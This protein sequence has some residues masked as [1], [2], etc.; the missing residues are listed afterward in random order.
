MQFTVYMITEIFRANYPI[1]SF[2]KELL[3][4][5][6]FLSVYEASLMIETTVNSNGNLMYNMVSSLLP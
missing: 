6:I 1:D 5:M 2:V 4:V 3:L